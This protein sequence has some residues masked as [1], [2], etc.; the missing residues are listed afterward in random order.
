[1]KVDW[2]VQVYQLTA[3]QQAILDRTPELAASPKA[4]VDALQLASSAVKETV[5][6]SPQRLS[7]GEAAAN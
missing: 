6:S 1:V 5:Q 2:V 3:A 7:S 4:I